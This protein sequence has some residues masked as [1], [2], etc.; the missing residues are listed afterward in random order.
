MNHILFLLV[1]DLGFHDVGFN[2]AEF[3]TPYI[4]KLAQEGTILSRYYVQSLCT[5]TRSAIMTG[6]YPYHSGLGHMVILEGQPYAVPKQETFLPQLLRAGGYR[7]HMVSVNSLQKF[8]LHNLPD[9]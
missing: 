4:D 7:T 2:G 3:T 5:P 6:R 9:M 1:D 8:K